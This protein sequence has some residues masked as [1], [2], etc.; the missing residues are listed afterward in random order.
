MHCCDASRGGIKSLKLTTEARAPDSLISS[1]SISTSGLS[2][3]LSLSLTQSSQRNHLM[4]VDWTSFTE[5]E[6]CLLANN[7]F[8]L[9][10]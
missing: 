9:L 3:S 5:L 6:N 8:L 1:T 2:L 7:A 10:Q 4:P